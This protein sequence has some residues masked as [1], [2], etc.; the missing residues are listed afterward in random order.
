MNFWQCDKN[1]LF[2]QLVQQHVL[3]EFIWIRRT[4]SYIWFN[5]NYCVLVNSRVRVRIRNRF[6]VCL[7]SSSTHISP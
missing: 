4:C 7:L 1:N 6:S 3:Y 2:V 5:V